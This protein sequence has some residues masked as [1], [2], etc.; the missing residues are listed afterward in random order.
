MPS[1]ESSAVVD[2]RKPRA[3]YVLQPP[4]E[5]VMLDLFARD[6]LK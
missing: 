2:T 6:E 4:S 1:L 3:R 5:A